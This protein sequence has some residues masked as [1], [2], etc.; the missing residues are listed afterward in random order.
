MEGS[1]VHEDL[2][3]MFAYFTIVLGS[4][5]PDLESVAKSVA[6]RLVADGNLEEAKRHL[7]AAISEAGVNAQVEV[8]HI[9][10]EVE[11]LGETFDR[12]ANY[13]DWDARYDDDEDAGPPSTP[14]ARNSAWFPVALFAISTTAMAI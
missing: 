6:A 13:T 12:W 9:E 8:L 3:I 2:T 11:S 7:Q 4:R 10:A 1:L 14:L 5:G